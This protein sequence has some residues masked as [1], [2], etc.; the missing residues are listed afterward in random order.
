M[1][2]RTDVRVRRGMK[3]LSG[4]GPV[5]AIVQQDRQVEVLRPQNR[6]LARIEHTQ[7]SIAECE[8]VND[9]PNGRRVKI[10][11]IIRL[12]T[13][14]VAI[15]DIRRSELDTKPVSK[16]AERPCRGHPPIPRYQ[17]QS[18]QPALRPGGRAEPAWGHPQRNLT[19]RLILRPGE[20]NS[21]IPCSW[22]R[23]ATKVAVVGP[24]SA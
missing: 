4:R 18:V 10:N 5:R 16:I 6:L 21:A 3:V 12:R 9:D 24:E 11:N 14:A 19:G 7:R 23:V 13:A 17:L 8:P 20:Q 1:I 2:M 15:A 22:C